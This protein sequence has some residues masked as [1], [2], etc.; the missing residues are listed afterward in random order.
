MTTP[1]G[2]FNPLPGGVQD[3][4]EH[5]WVTSLTIVDKVGV[6][7]AVGAGHTSVAAG[8]YLILCASALE[9][10]GCLFPITTHSQA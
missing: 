2:A 10:R 1:S 3:V 7:V 6:A 9:E 8:L 5:Q 4:Q